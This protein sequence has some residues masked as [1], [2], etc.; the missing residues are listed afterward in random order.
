VNLDDTNPIAEFSKAVRLH[1][2]LADQ[3]KADLMAALPVLTETLSHP[4]GQ[5][6]KVAVILQ[7]CWNGLLC[8]NLASLDA[9]V[10]KA[11]IGLIAARAHLSSETAADFQSTVLFLKETVAHCSGQSAKVAAILTSVV[12]GELDNALD[13][14]D[15]KV[16]HGVVAMVAAR[17]YLSGDADSL[18][19]PLINRK[20]GRQS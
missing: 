18:L 1:R 4:S 16:A 13:G 19:R 8:D 12:D 11:V 6:A 10:A 20:E 2:Q 3:A 5:S 15:S 9:K 14:L 17:A 7:S